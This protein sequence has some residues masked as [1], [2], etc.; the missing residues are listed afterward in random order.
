[1]RAVADTGVITIGPNQILRISGDGVDQD[2]VIALRFRRIGYQATFE[3]PG[4]TRYSRV[5]NVITNPILVTGGDGVSF[6]VQ[7]NQI[8]TDATRVIVMSNRPN[9]RVNAALIDA[10]TGT[11][12]VLV[13]LLIP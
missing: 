7:G 11:T 5:S 4:I 8:G 1:M 3:A 13:G 6:S 2:D 9:V 10:A 12:Q